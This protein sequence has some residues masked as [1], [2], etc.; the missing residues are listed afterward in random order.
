MDSAPSLWL[1][2]G[3]VA[4][5]SVRMHSVSKCF[6]DRVMIGQSKGRE[7]RGQGREH[8]HVIGRQAWPWLKQW[9]TGTRRQKLQQQREKKRRK[10]I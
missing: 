2:L 9:D 5:T 1:P 7:A 10:T 8:G 4:H 3:L 6:T